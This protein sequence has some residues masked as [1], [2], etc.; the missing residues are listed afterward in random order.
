MPL[1]LLFYSILLVFSLLNYQD[2]ARSNK[3]KCL[4]NLSNYNAWTR[5]IENAG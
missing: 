2:D 3:H 1:I 5:A 4:Q